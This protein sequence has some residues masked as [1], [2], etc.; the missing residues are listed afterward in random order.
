MSVNGTVAAPPTLMVVHAH[1]DD[2]C[3]GT[4]GTLA[5]YSAE[6][7]NTV[8]V[9]ATRGEEGEIHDPNLTEEEARP[10]LG[11]IR[12]GELTRA[13]A[14]LGVSNL[15]FLGYRDSGMMGTPANEH[16]DNFHNANFDEAVG[17]L[18]ALIRRHRPQVLVTYNEDG[19][20]GH[21]DHL[22]SHKVTAA[23]YEAAGDPARYPEAGP[24]WEPS[25]FYAI[26][27]SRENWRRLRDE[28]KA[29]GIAWPRDNDEEQEAQSASAEGEGEP[30][31]PEALGQDLAAEGTPEAKEQSEEEEGWGQPE[32]SIS[33]F[34]DTGDY[35]RVVRDALRE[36]RTQ[37]V[38]FF[39]DLPEDLAAKTR[40]TDYFVLL[41]SR[42]DS[43]LPESDLFAGVRTAAPEAVAVTD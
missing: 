14:H 15:E 19:G 40:A 9:T 35:W 25:K 24:A 32:S 41:R 5:R 37:P 8:L 33:A 20:Y 13:V 38:G 2:E 23:A 27:W 6:G 39:L 34:I 43:S 4:G 18:V 42:V 12:T 29:R 16:P 10:R 7:V 28:L 31:A 17:R 21:P 11:E 36:H 22:Q 1:P 3:L 26:A 30:I